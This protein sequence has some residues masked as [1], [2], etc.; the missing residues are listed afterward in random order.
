M[1]K[2]IRVIGNDGQLVGR[3][4]HVVA[5]R[6]AARPTGLVIE[7]EH[8][9]GERVLPLTEV[10]GAHGELVTLTADSSHYRDLPRFVRTGYRVIDEEM[11]MREQLDEDFQVGADEPGEPAAGPGS[12]PGAADAGAA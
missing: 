5:E 11:E 1:P 4:A 7:H 9:G 8:D 2:T 10:H 6:D 3:L 12:G